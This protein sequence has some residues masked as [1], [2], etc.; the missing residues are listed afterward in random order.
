MVSGVSAEHDAADR[1][2]A[3]RA[4]LRSPVLD[5]AK[6]GFDLVANHEDWLRRWFLGTCDWRLVVDRRRGFARLHKVPDPDSRPRPPLRSLR[7]DARPFDRRRYVLF[8]VTAVAIGQFPRGQ[9]SLQDLSGRVADLTGADE[10]LTPYDASDKAERLALVDVLD[11]LRSYRVLTTLDQRD[12]YETDQNANALYIIDDRRLSQLFTR[13]D[14]DAEESSRFSVMRRLL[15]DP[16]LLRDDLDGEQREFLA[17][18]SRSIRRHLAEA[19]LL[20]ERRAG[21]WCAVDPTGESTDLRFPQPNTITHQAALL[22]I[23]KLGRRREDVTDWVPA[24]RLRHLLA[25]LMAEHP[26]WAKG[27]RVDGGLD[28]LATEVLDVLDAFG[29]IRRDEIGFE[30]TPAA[31]RFRDVVVTTTGEKK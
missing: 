16:V 9:V 6:S 24:T 10:E 21:G 17:G 20:L 11:L 4:L 29:L 8:C 23:S 26:R 31:G 15:D 5:R 12:D 14:P 7:S 3:I 27:H 30:L 13:R 22:V 2:R 28:K 18:S 25:D 19:G 1:A